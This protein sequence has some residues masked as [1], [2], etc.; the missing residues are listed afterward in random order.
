MLIRNGRKIICVNRC[1]ERETTPAHDG[2]LAAFDIATSFD[3]D[4]LDVDSDVDV[5]NPKDAWTLRLVYNDGNREDLSMVKPNDKKNDYLITSKDR[6]RS[7]FS[8]NDPKDKTLKVPKDVI[9]HIAKHIAQAQKNVED[10]KGERDSDLAKEIAFDIK[11]EFPKYDMEVIDGD[12][13]KN[14]WNLQVVY[15]D[16]TK[17]S[18]S[19]LK[20]GKTYLMKSKDGFIGK[21]SLSELKDFPKKLKDH[22]EGHA[23]K[24]NR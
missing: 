5:K 15:K 7:K 16:G 12:V 10:E 23:K 19:I 11:K 21:F 13:G 18:F 4:E 1:Y 6:L 20:A 3:K 2:E 8:D 17:D 24:S 14:Y 22:I 9:D